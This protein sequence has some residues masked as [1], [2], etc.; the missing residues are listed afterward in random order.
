MLE[1]LQ[2]YLEK[3]LLSSSKNASHKISIYLNCKISIFSTIS[4]FF[5][6]KVLYT[7]FMPKQEKSSLKPF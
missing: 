5:F 4:F 7:E 2:Y 1:Q 3:I 6:Y